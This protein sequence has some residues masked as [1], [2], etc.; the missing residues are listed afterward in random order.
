MFEAG[1]QI[2]D[3]KEMLGHDLDTETVT[4]G[5]RRCLQRAI[6]AGIHH[7]IDTRFCQRLGAATST[8]DPT[9]RIVDWPRRC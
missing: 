1:V 8:R 3:I 7:Q 6:R 9:D 5:L 4:D 2:D